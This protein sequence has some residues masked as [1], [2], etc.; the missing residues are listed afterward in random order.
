MCFLNKAKMIC[1][2]NHLFKRE[3]SYRRNLFLKNDYPTWFLDQS[4]EKVDGRDK[5]V[6]QKPKPN[7]SRSIEVPYCGKS[8]YQFANPHI[9]L[10]RKKF[11]VDIS[12]Y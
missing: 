1:F 11:H 6:T 2:N 10:V 5:L 9:C 4:L 7:F 3:I 8:S 12:V